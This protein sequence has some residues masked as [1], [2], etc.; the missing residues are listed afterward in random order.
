MAFVYDNKTYRNLQQQVKEN[1]LDNGEKIFDINGEEIVFDGSY[2]GELLKENFSGNE[3]SEYLNLQIVDEGVIGDFFK[4]TYTY[5][6]GKIAK[7]GKIFVSFF[8]DKVLPVMMPVTSQVALKSG[9]IPDSK[10]LHWLG[11]SEDARYS[12]VDTKG[13]EILKSRPSTIECWKAAAQRMGTSV[14]ES[15][16]G[17]SL[18]QILEVLKLASDD[19]Q[20]L[21]VDEAMLEHLVEKVIRKGAKA[22]PLLS[23]FLFRKT[24]LLQHIRKDGACRR[25]TSSRP[26]CRNIACCRICHHTLWQCFRIWR[27]RISLQH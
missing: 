18:N 20:V 26:A 14:H 17:K 6:K 3:L 27:H 21:N 5:L 19:N 16:K 9:D 7:V 11:N 22:Q 4:K 1:M 24:C 10:Y 25:Q 2:D 15:Q 8:N 12:G 23:R 13:D